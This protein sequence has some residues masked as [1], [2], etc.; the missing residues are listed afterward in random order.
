MFLVTKSLECNLL[1]TNDVY[2]GRQQRLGLSELHLL[3][4]DNTAQVVDVNDSSIVSSQRLQARHL[5]QIP[6]VLYLQSSCR[7]RLALPVEATTS[8]QEAL[9]GGSTY[10]HTLQHLYILL[11][12]N[13]V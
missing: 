5:R 4:Q 3:Q 13:A 11:G 9:V 6:N 8:G 10:Q 1:A 2:T 7:C 12:G